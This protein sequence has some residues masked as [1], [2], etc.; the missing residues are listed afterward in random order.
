MPAEH[1]HP[2]RKE[3]MAPGRLDNKPDRRVRPSE[4]LEAGTTHFCG[5]PD[6]FALRPAPIAV[7][8]RRPSPR[9]V[10]VQPNEIYENSCPPARPIVQFAGNPDEGARGVFDR[11]HRVVPVGPRHV[12]IG[13]ILVALDR[14]A[15]EAAEQKVAPLKLPTRMKA[16]WCNV[17]N[18]KMSRQSPLAVAA[19]APQ[20]LRQVANRVAVG[21]VG[22]RR[23]AAVDW[24]HLGFPVLLA[25]AS[26]LRMA[27][28]PGF[29]E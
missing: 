27:P 29:S 19:I 18:C 2:D 13:Y 15:I 28:S 8:G 24:P 22:P 21:S 10:P 11:Q 7:G 3:P 5:G 17:L 12:P 20:P 16:L 6:L 9:A 4:A 25:R 1:G 23:G 26:S 14:V